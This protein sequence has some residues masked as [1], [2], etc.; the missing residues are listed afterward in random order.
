MIDWKTAKRLREALRVRAWV[1]AEHIV[2]EKAEPEPQPRRVVHWI[3]EGE[4]LGNVERMPEADV[5]DFVKRKLESGTN[6]ISIHG[7]YV[8]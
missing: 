7:R 5:P 1:I 8:K 2:E 3:N 6:Q 4:G